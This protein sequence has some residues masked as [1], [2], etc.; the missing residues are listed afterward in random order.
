MDAGGIDLTSQFTTH[1]PIP[2]ETR[3]KSRGKSG[4]TKKDTGPSKSLCFQFSFYFF[5]THTLTHSL[6]QPKKKKEPSSLSFLISAAQIRGVWETLITS[7]NKNQFYYPSLL[8]H[9]SPINRSL[10]LSLS[11]SMLDFDL[12]LTVVSD[13]LLLFN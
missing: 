6:N 2:I 3:F 12:N 13:L 9:F 1:I 10:S 8:L 11:D 5:L 7:H 4:K